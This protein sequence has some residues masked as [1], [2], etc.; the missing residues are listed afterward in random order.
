MLGGERCA[1]AIL[2]EGFQLLVSFGGLNRFPGY[3]MIIPLGAKKQ[4]SAA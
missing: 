1:V 4:I 3:V 2:Q